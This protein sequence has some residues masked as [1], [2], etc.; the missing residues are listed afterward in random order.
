MR[1]AIVEDN[2]KDTEQLRSVIDAY[3]T[4]RKMPVELDTFSSGSDFLRDF[5]PQKYDLVFFDNY[6]GNGLGINFARKA[7]AID[8]KVEFVFVSMSPEFAVSG[9]EVRALH[10]L[11]KPATISA[12]AQVFE[13]FWTRTAKPDI[14]MVELKSDYR[15][16][17]LPLSSIRYIEVENKTCLV[18]ADEDVPVHLPLEKVM[19]LLPPGTFVRTHK[20]YAVRLGAIQSMKQSEF[21]L[22]D[23]GSVPIGRT[24]QKDC[25]GAFIEYLTSHQNMKDTNFRQ[26]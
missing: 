19:E 4:E 15:P 23:G 2:E 12:I 26:L 11:L 5:A 13:R 24:Y 25:K 20:G 8:E 1:I 3:T 17:L 21:L 6:I 10:Y 18:R 14:P 9:F 16:V 22:K 7:R